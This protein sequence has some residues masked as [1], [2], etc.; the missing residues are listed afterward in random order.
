MFSKDL[1]VLIEAKKPNSKEFITH[2]KV[3]SK[4]LHGDYFILF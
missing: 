1:E 2:T 4:A 3:N